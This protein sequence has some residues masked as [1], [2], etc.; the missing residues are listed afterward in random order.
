ME[1]TH[2]ETLFHI[3]PQPDDFAP[4]NNYQT[5]THFVKD[6]EGDST[7]TVKVEVTQ[8]M[9]DRVLCVF[10]SLSKYPDTVKK[11]EIIG[12]DVWKP[13]VKKSIIEC[14]NLYKKRVKTTYL[15]LTDIPLPIME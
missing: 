6:I 10:N 8:S 2:S 7:F 4:G 1:E 15:E 5:K 13:L 14:N 11:G 3:Y 12:M 9:G